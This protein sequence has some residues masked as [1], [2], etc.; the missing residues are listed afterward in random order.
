MLIE[1]GDAEQQLAI[2]LEY[3]VIKNQQSLLR[4][5]IF[6]FSMSTKFL[7]K[8]HGMSQYY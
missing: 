5:N 6:P 1:R 4:V 2:M 7:Q 8:S 3:A